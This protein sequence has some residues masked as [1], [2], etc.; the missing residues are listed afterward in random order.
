[1][2][3]HSKTCDC[4][5]QDV[6]CTF[7]TASIEG[8]NSKSRSNIR[9]GSAFACLLPC[10]TSD[11]RSSTSRMKTADASASIVRDDPQAFTLFHAQCSAPSTTLGLG[12]AVKNTRICAH[13]G[14]QSY[15]P[16]TMG[17]VALLFP[18]FLKPIGLSHNSFRLNKTLSSRQSSGY[19]KLLI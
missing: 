2:S 10:R 7:D 15:L 1:M 14:N 18:H 17:K 9:S 19:P 12:L 3:A 8:R 5:Q 16:N 13:H 4:T 11:P 6:W